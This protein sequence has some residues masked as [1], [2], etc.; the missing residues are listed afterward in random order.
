MT[1]GLHFAIALFLVFSVPAFAAKPKFVPK[2]SA[3]PAETK[4]PP[5]NQGILDKMAKQIEAGLRNFGVK[6]VAILE[7]PYL[8]GHA[9]SGPAMVQKE[10]IA[11]LERRGVFISSSAPV[12]AKGDLNDIRGKNKVQEIG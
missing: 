4:N 7:F 12:F 9:G 2:K 5:E 11:S 10:L 6:S 1:K 8:D 3:K